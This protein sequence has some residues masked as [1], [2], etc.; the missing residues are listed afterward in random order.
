MMHPPFGQRIFL[1]AA[2]A[3]SSITRGYCWAILMT[4]VSRSH[5]LIQFIRIPL[6]IHFFKHAPPEFQSI[7]SGF[8][9][10][11]PGTEK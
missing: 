1:I 2:I 10:S 4:I 8:L 9:F 7:I 11:S 6:Q 3:D 5:H